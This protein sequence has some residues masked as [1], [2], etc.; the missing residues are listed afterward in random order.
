VLQD[1]AAAAATS[2]ARTGDPHSPWSRRD[3]W[4]LGAAEPLELRFHDGAAE[5]LVRL[6]PGTVEIDEQTH[7]AALLATGTAQVV[8]F[9]GAR[10]NLSIGRHGDV[11]TVI[12]ATETCRLVLRD[13]LAPPA[14]SERASGGLTAPMTGKV[15]AV[16]VAPGARVARGQLLVLIEAMKMEH[17]ITAPADGVV[18]AIHYAAGDLV[19]EGALLLALAAADAKE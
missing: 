11:L 12:G 4:R 3:F 15:L 7:S 18:E 1:G 14:G 8:E 2:A 10:E 5:R 16:L 13:P 6:R 19:D 9:D 17:A